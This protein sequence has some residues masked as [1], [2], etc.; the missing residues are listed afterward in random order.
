MKL[1]T[2][3]DIAKIF[4]VKE[5]TVQMWR[6]RGTGPPYIVAG[7]RSIRFDPLEVESYIKSRQ[8]KST[9]KLKNE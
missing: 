7:D 2:E 6:V 5:Q 3:K 8:R 4:K 1:L 9:K